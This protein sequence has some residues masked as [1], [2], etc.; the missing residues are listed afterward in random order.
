MSEIRKLQDDG[1]VFID[2][3]TD[4]SNP[5]LGC[6]VCCTHFRISFY[7]GELDTKPMG[8]VP[9]EKTSKINDF[10][11]CMKGTETGGRCVALLGTPGE[12]ISCAIYSNRPTPC[13][14]FPVFMEDG[15]PNPKCNELRSKAG[16]PLIKP[17]QSEQV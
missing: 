17:L 2:M 13:R 1:R 5:C 8:F 12:N 15:N 9:N 16:I 6:G 7:F 3:P 14:E 10:F 11:A 4:E